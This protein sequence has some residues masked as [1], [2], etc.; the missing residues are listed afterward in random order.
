M[1][2]EKYIPPY[3]ITDEMLNLAIEISNLLSELKVT[4]D[5]NKTPKLRQV[6][7]VKSIQ[8]SLAIEENTLN[9][10]EVNAI[11]NGKEVVGP[12]NDIVAV[13][14]ALK[15][16]S[17]LDELDPYSIDDLLKAHKV[18]MLGLVDH[19]GC[20]RT[21]NVGVYS[22]DGTVS[23][24]APPHERVNNLINDLFTWLKDSEVNALIK[25][26]V[27]HYEFEFT[28]PFM[29][30]NGRMG[31]LWQTLLLSKWQ[32]IFKWLPIENMIYKKQEEYYAAI[33]E[34]TSCGNSNPFIIYML[35]I[36]K[37]TINEIISE[38]RSEITHSYKGMD[39]LMSVIK[40]YPQSLNELMRELH[41]KNREAFR[42]N[43]IKPALES[44]L[45]KMSDPAHPHSRNQKYYKG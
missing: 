7:R 6:N 22:A 14:N 27:F 30:G 1:E 8:A 3:T 17:L 21:G 36:I 33:R 34:S 16:Y 43:Y 39:K 9:Y 5:L 32:P 20:L 44:G 24:M 18:M 31:R 35:N 38:S 28:H 11:V 2:Y 10:D 4:D 37:D 15:A 40:E 13:N 12:I 42:R 41:L 23:H 29:D 19:P 26:S 25:S 45:I